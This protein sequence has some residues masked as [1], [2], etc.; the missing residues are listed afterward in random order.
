MNLMWPWVAVATLGA[1]HG[2][3][4]SM[5]WLF[6]VALGLQEE[7]RTKVISALFPIAVGHLVSVGAIVGLMAMAMRPCATSTWKYMTRSC[8]FSW[9]PPAAARA[10]H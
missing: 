3:D 1:Y 6:A 7:R 4:P 2:I 9:D 5:G 8:W 10:R